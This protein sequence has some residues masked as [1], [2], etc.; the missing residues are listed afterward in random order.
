[1][2]SKRLAIP[3]VLWGAS[4]FAGCVPL[5]S[6]DRV[7]SPTEAEFSPPAVGQGADLFANDATIQDVETAT[8]FAPQLQFSVQSLNHGEEPA[9]TTNIYQTKGELEI[10]ETHTLL[11]NATFRFDKLEVGKEAGYGRMEVGTPPKMTLDVSVRV[12]SLESKD[13]A[14]LSVKAKNLLAE[15]YVA[16]LRIKQMPGGLFISSLGNATRANDKNGVHTTEVSARVVQT[17]LPGLIHLP[18]APGPMR[19]RTLIVAEPDPADR[20]NAQKV[21][22]QTYAIQ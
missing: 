12:T 22:R 16:D 8:K 14:L 11:E 18:D 7:A 17:L 1:M 19:T 2:T 5:P 21:F 13:T 3:V 20:G 9:V 10:R 15:V 4:L 6:N